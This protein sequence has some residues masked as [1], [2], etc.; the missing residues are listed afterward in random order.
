MRLR[1]ID[2]VGMLAFALSIAAC[3]S[4][5]PA[6]PHASRSVQ[7][8]D[9]F[10]ANRGPDQVMTEWAGLIPGLTGI[11]P[12][13]DGK[14][15]VIVTDISAAQAV[16]AIVV[17][18]ANERLPAHLPRMT[19]ERVVIEAGDFT[20]MQ[21]REWYPSFQQLLSMPGTTFTDIDERQGKLR[22]GLENIGLRS[23]VLSKAHRWGIP[24]S[25][26]AI[27][28]SGPI[29]DD[30][31]TW[32]RRRPVPG[33][34]VV[35]FV[36]G[37]VYDGCTAGMNLLRSSVRYLVTNSHCGYRNTDDNI[38]LENDSSRQIA[39]EHFDLPF[40]TGAGCPAGRS[41]RFSDAALFA[42]YD[43][44]SYDLGKILYTDYQDSITINNFRLSI[45]S[46][47]TQCPVP[48]VSCDYDNSGGYYANIVG[49]ISGWTDGFNTATCVDSNPAGTSY[50][51]L[52]Q[53]RADYPSQAGDSGSMV[54]TTVTPATYTN[55]RIWGIHW[56]KDIN[57][58]SYYS[59]IHNVFAEMND[60]FTTY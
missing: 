10:W 35:R 38:V 44:V 13:K 41:C 53:M 37:G 17:A 49:G 19:A 34:S 57:N 16:V 6:A 58:Q 29:R 32:T 42:Y 21:L 2:T 50:T 15:H 48:G 18:N 23:E 11:Y 22:V 7:A 31:S 20:W 46:T 30:S 51:Y 3:D 25:A 5:E 8:S 14:M 27:E 1:T 36:K 39:V 33:S 60:N 56:A 24:E 40:W 55:V 26:I 59:L 45:T 28:V 4:N 54:W 43:S 52:C 47:G 9:G 12:G